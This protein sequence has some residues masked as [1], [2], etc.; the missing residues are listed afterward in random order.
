MSG[1]R[2]V[3]VVGGGLAGA[4]AAWQLVRRG[5]AVELWEMRPVKLTPAHTSGFL[6]E[7][8]CS[9]SLRGDSL[10][11]AV[12]LLKE[13]MR[14][15]GSLIMAQA[16]RHRLPGGGALVVDRWEFARGVTGV[17]E[18]HPLVT[19]H[20]EEISDI[21]PD[22][23][24]VI[25]TGPLTSD[26]L[27]RAL[28]ELTGK[29]FLYFYDAAS[30]IVTA[31]SLDYG[32]VFRA[33]RY[34]K[35]EAAYLNCPLDRQQYEVFYQE[36]VKARV[37]EP[38]AF[39][40]VEFFEG[41]LPLEEMARRGPDTLRFGPLKPVGLVDPRTGREPY[42]V[43][44]LRPEN[45]EGSLWSLVGFQTRLQWGEQERVFRLIPGLERAEFVRLGVMHRNTY[46]NSPGVLA[47]TYALEKDAGLFFAGQITGVEGYVESAASGLVAGINAAR[48]ALGKEPL[49]FP[50]E[51]AIGALAHYI[52]SAVTG[53]FQPMNINFGLI[54]ASDGKSRDR[55]QRRREMARRALEALENFIQ[56]S[57][58]EEDVYE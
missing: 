7:L 54:V 35:G 22:R 15:L 49:V 43:V 20:R 8:V 23:P 58:L 42:A 2:R 33:S 26:D 11:N 37:H 28:Q 13:E 4:E 30:P 29:E 50:V 56:S 21:L 53:R 1:T 12:G 55:L 32:V 19:L 36:L 40:K 27:A 34:G 25:A 14:R 48:L 24:A 57:W 31:E 39:E 9:N 51:T 45:A 44:Q 6:A 52:S 18:Q 10:E 46:L 3:T 41:C 17:L 38:H 16:G 47:A 5:V